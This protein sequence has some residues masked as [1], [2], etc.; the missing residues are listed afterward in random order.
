M[1][2]HEH[3]TLDHQL[4]HQHAPHLNVEMCQSHHAYLF[5]LILVELFWLILVFTLLMIHIVRT[6]S[7]LTKLAIND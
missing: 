3:L 7:P 6:L 1:V 2:D 5:G 4:Q